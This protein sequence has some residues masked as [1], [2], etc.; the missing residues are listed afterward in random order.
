MSVQSSR[1]SSNKGFTLVE[2]LI[3]V[4]IIGVLASQGVPAYRRMIQKSKKGEAQVMLGNISTAESGFFSEYGT[5]GNNIARMGAMMD[6]YQDV[7]GTNYTYTAGVGL[8]PACGAQLAAGAI[9]P[10]PGLVAA[11]ASNPQYIQPVPGTGLVSAVN[12]TN[13]L[14]RLS[15]INCQASA[16]DATNV[17]QNTFTASATG[18]IRGGTVNDMNSCGPTGLAGCDQWTINQNRQMVNVV[19]GVN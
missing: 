1:L 4:A 13:R 10:T 18:Y 2:L 19:D 12:F 3:V 17:T 6:G 15:L 16:F 8:S 5:Y 9:L 11:I 14:G 7:N